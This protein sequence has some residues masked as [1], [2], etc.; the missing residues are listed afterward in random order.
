[1]GKLS[2]KARAIKNGLLIVWLKGSAVNLRRGLFVRHHALTQRKTAMSWSSLPIDYSEQHTILVF[3]YTAQTSS[4]A[5]KLHHQITSKANV[6][7]MHL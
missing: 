3:Q 7:Q 5:E 1:V 2:K 4:L 6:L